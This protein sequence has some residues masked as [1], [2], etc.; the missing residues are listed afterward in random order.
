MGYTEI[1]GG[2]NVIRT[3]F[4]FD[5]PLKRIFMKSFVTAAKTSP[6]L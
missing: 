5:V 1:A 6:F 2:Y 4:A 3:L